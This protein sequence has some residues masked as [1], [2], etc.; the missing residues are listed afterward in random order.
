MDEEKTARQRRAERAKSKGSGIQFSGD[1]LRKLI[2]PAIIVLVLA[3]I[4]FAMVRWNQQFDDCPGHWHSTMKVYADG[5]EVT[6]DAYNLENKNLPM[7]YHMH[8]GDA[9]WKWHFEPQGGAEC[10]PF[11]TP[12][13][14]IDMRVS[15]GKLTFGGE[16]AGMPWAGEHV[17]NE[18]HTLQIF[19]EPPGESW[20]TLTAKQLNNRQ[21]KDGERL[22]ILFGNYTD[23]EIES[24]KASVPS[25]YGS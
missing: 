17:A 3:A 21:L 13:R 11:S 20:S 2:V 14:A 4:V 7:A 8:Q 19:H 25:P 12:S 23:D 15:A 1:W 6:F 18:T 9:R 16:H 22:L 10:I 24:L 5:N